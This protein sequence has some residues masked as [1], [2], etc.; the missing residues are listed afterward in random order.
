[1]LQ[2]GG[3]ALAVGIEP[4]QPKIAELHF[5]LQLV[6]PNLKLIAA[7][8]HLIR[9]QRETRQIIPRPACQRH[10]AIFTQYHPRPI[11]PRLTVGAMAHPDQVVIQHVDGQP[12]PARSAEAQRITLRYLLRQRN[13]H[14]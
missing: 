8:F 3:E 12:F 6:R 13:L 4:F 7:G 5:D 1:M 14:Q 9:R 2:V 10:F 11:Q